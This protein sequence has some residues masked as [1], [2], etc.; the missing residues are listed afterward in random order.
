[1][2]RITFL[3]LP[4]FLC[5]AL[6]ACGGGKAEKTF[7]PAADAKILLSSGAFSEELTEIDRDIACATYGIDAATVTGSAVYGSTGTTAEELAIFTLKDADAAQVALQQLQYR[8]EDRTDSMK[9]YIPA[10]VPK[11]EK[12]VVTSRG[13]SVLLVV[14]NDYSPVN[15]FLEG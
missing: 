6:A 13:N 11:L 7:D 12:A 8:V 14:A 5:L 2:K 10:E 15:T 9:S 1:M 3:A 4:L